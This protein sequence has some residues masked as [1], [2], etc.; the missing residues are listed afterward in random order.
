MIASHVDDWM[1]IGDEVFEEEIASKL[2]DTF[3]LSKVETKSF[4]YCGCNVVIR[5]S[6][7]IEL[8]QNDY[9]DTLEL[10]EELDGEDDRELN[11]RE[12]K[13]VRGKIGELLWISLLTR[14]DLSFDVN[15]LSS[16]VSNG[17]VLTAKNINKLL[18]KAKKSRNILRFSKLG[19]L[20]QLRV[21]KGSKT[22]NLV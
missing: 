15:L 16:Q 17:T 5:E 12:K 19:D 21:K 11:T 10:M 20:S 3:K 7:I 9:I 22:R 8:D 2:K 4:K 14:P 1:V 18:K 6:G 13:Q